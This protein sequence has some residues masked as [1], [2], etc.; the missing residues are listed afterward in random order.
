MGGGVSSDNY[1]LHYL[2]EDEGDRATPLFSID[3]NNSSP[4]KPLT[5]SLSSNKIESDKKITLDNGS[6]VVKLRNRSNSSTASM[7]S[8]K[9]LLV[10]QKSIMQPTQSKTNCSDKYPWLIK[11]TKFTASSLTDFEFG[12][13]IG[14]YFTI[15]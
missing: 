6:S 13:I 15:N 8:Q 2:P 3:N 7:K 5:R 12:R 11:N 10:P 9:P 4:T 1:V 14:K